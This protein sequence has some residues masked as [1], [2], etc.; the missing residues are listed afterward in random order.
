MLFSDFWLGGYFLPLVFDYHIKFNVIK[1]VNS[2]NER[3]Y[4][5]VG[6]EKG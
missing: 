3:P 4:L 2:F 5:F 1:D 6:M